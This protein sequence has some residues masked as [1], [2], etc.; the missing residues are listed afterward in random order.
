MIRYN[1]CRIMKCLIYCNNVLREG[2][3]FERQQSARATQQKSTSRSTFLLLWSSGCRGAP[4]GRPTAAHAFCAGHGV[5]ARGK[6]E[7]V[8]RIRPGRRDPAKGTA[9]RVGKV[10]SNRESDRE[11]RSSDGSN[12]GDEGVGS[13]SG[14][15]GQGPA[16]VLAGGFTTAKKEAR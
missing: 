8:R 9:D 11:G 1:M 13:G 3:T 15:A 2:S 5:R 14:P 10:A 4:P 6:I 7:G 12:E 16:L